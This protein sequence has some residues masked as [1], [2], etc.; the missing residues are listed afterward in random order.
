MNVERCTVDATELDF[1][2]A[3]AFVSSLWDV[4]I[5]YRPTRNLVCTSAPAGSR[6]R[7]GWQCSLIVASPWRGTAY[8]FRL[9]V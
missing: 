9:S 5:M 1:V 7:G 2:V 3:V 8:S 6:E 4:V